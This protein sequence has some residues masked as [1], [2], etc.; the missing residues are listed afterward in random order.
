MIWI[1]R[2]NYIFDF[3][4]RND[5]LWRSYFA[6]AFFWCSGKYLM[7]RP[8]NI[9]SFVCFRYLLIHALTE[10]PRCSDANSRKDAV[11]GA[12][13]ADI[14]LMIDCAHDDDGMRW[15]NDWINEWFNHQCFN[16]LEHLENIQTDL[17]PRK[18]LGNNK[19]QY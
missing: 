4:L 12:A 19:K 3:T 17:K 9:N 16:L 7:P 18:H 6:C 5:A 11:A 10:E 8:R 14:R 13:H 15:M 2:L 1:N